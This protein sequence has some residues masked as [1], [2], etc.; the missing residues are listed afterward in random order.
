[1]W[2]EKDMLADFRTMDMALEQESKPGLVVAVL[3]ALAVP[4]APTATAV[5]RSGARRWMSA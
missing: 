1:M 2:M 4:T 3:A 5:W